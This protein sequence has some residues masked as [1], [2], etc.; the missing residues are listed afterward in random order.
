MNPIKHVLVVDDDSDL[1]AF[2]AETLVG[3]DPGCCVSVARS[4]EE[5][6]EKLYQGPVDVLVT[7]LRMS[8]IDGLALIRWA[9]AFH[10]DVPAILMTGDERR[11]L[12]VRARSCRAWRTVFKSSGFTERLEQAVRDALRAPQ[13]RRAAGSGN[14]GRV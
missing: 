10:P 4:G 2:I 8:G 3:A 7:D 13:A 11:E 14:D 9:R 12:A 5:A 6:L 1:A